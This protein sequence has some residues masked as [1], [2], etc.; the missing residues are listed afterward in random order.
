M[1]HNIAFI[2]REDD[3]H[4]EIEFLVVDII[5]HRRR[6]SYYVSHADHPTITCFTRNSRRSY[7]FHSAGILHIWRWIHRV[8]WGIAPRLT[9]FSI[10]DWLYLVDYSSKY[11][12]YVTNYIEYMSYKFGTIRVICFC[13]V[14]NYAHRP[15]HIYQQ[16]YKTLFNALHKRTTNDSSTRKQLIL[17][18]A[19]TMFCPD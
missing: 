4:N 7:Q 10:I 11:I 18:C 6:Q 3:H 9:Y 8:G 14:I 5:Y 17:L 2:G 12:K 13:C 1:R 19:M 15:N 16:K